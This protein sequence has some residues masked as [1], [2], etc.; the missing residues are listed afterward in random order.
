VPQEVL[1]ALGSLV[2]V[3]FLAAAVAA[4][5]AAAGKIAEQEK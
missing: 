4:A 5:V 1:A 2:A 3:V